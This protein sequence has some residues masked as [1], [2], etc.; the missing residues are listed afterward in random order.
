MQVWN[1]REHKRWLPTGDADYKQI[2]N[3]PREAAAITV[4]HH[5]ASRCGV[6][7]PAPTSTCATRLP[8]SFGLGNK[9]GRYAVSHP[10]ALP[11]P[12]ASGQ[13]GALQVGILERPP[14]MSRT[15]LRLQRRSTLALTSVG[16][17]LVGAASRGRPAT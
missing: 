6:S 2:P 3:L 15:A 13:D 14:A 10:A 8:Y 12:P 7:P 9:H 5:G 11:S 1:R 16:L 4:P 17:R